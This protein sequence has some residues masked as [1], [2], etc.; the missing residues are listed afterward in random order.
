MLWISK[1]DY[2]HTKGDLLTK[3]LVL[4]HDILGYLLKIKPAKTFLL[5]LLVA[6][7]DAKGK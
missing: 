6:S 2:V 4:F 3:N 7:N 1:V 5:F